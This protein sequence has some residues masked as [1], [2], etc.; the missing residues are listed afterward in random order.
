[1]FVSFLNGIKQ[2]FHNKKVVLLSGGSGKHL[3]SLSND[4]RSKQ[5]ITIFM[6]A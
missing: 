1:M 3:W 6:T 4:I 2:Q 5:L